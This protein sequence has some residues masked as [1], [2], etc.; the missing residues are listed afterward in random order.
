MSRFVKKKEKDED[1]LYQKKKK[2]KEQQKMTKRMRKE[3]K[4]RKKNIRARR[5][6][7]DGM[8]ELMRWKEKE[9]KH[10]MVGMGER[11]RT[12]REKW[13]D[14]QEHEVVML[15]LSIKARKLSDYRLVE[16]RR[17]PMDMFWKCWD[18]KQIERSRMGNKLRE[19]VKKIVNRDCQ[20]LSDNL[21]C[22]DNSTDKP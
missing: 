5:A 16:E 15:N 9:K 10:G 1:D 4:K 13:M 20:L 18:S 17:T 12:A 19:E 14:C 21:I 22:H 7:L 11:A 6:R 3:R 2:E 8:E